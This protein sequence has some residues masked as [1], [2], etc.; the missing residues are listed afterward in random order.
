MDELR[1]VTLDGKYAGPYEVEAICVDGRL[2]VRPEKPSERTKG[3][4]RKLTSAEFDA[5]CGKSPAPGKS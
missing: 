3:V 5:L 1:R 2:L 4:T